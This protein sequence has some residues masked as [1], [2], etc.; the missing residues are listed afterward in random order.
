MCSVPPFHQKWDQ[1]LFL[2]WNK[3]CNSLKWWP[4]WNC[5]SNWP[6]LVSA[7]PQTVVLVSNCDPGLKLTLDLKSICHHVT[8]NEKYLVA[9]LCNRTWNIYKFIFSTWL[10]HTLFIF[11][12]F[13]AP[14]Q[15]YGH[16]LVHLCLLLVKSW[17]WLLVIKCQI[18]T[19]ILWHRTQSWRIDK[20]AVSPMGLK[21]VKQ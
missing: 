2:A 21:I 5:D 7:W 3:R 20:M 18:M 17:L 6:S 16:A 11:S 13:N 15:T 14:S 4:H 12:C 1:K 9:G 10:I 19:W 8:S